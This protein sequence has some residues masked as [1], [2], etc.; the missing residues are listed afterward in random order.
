M[1]ISLYDL[2]YEKHKKGYMYASFIEMSKLKELELKNVFDLKECHYK[3]NGL[4]FSK[5]ENF[6][7]ENYE[8]DGHSMVPEWFSFLKNDWNCQLNEYS[9]RAIIF[10]KFNESKIGTFSYENLIPYTDL[11]Q[12][13]EVKNKNFSFDT[14]FDWDKYAKNEWNGI[15]VEHKNFSG[16]CWDV[17]TVVVWNWSALLDME[18]YEPFDNNFYYK[19]DNIMAKSQ[20]DEC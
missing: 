14:K 3:P 18:V 15:S 10:A 8:V 16:V 1:S 13:K 6:V 5:L 9:K 4:Y 2:C 17:N 7:N 12:S 20:C 19:L 11:S